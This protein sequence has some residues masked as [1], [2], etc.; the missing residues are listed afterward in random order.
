[1]QP[2]APARAAHPRGRLG[3]AGNQ[4]RLRT[5]S[6]AADQTFTTRSSPADAPR[7]PSGLRATAYTP[8]LCSLTIV[9]SRPAA[10]SQS[11]TV[12]S[13][14]HEARRRASALNDTV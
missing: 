4:S 3:L 1:H 5:A 14:P 13:A 7:R 9:S 12:A 10:T 8:R 6:L 2:D 11:R